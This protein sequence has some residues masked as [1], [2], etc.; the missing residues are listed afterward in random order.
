MWGLPQRPAA[1]AGQH[2]PCGSSGLDSGPS[3][4]LPL[5]GSEW[6]PRATRTLSL[7]LFG[8]LLE[9]PMDLLS[10]LKICTSSNYPT[11]GYLSEENENTNL[12]K[13][14][15]AYVHSSI[16]YNRK[17]WWWGSNTLAS[18][19]K[20]PMHWKRP[21]WWKRLMAGG[22]RADRGW[23]GWMASLTQWTWVWA[24]SKRSWRTEK[25]GM[26]QSMGSQRVGHNS[27]TEKQEDIE[28]N[29]SAHW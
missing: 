16:I 14:M 22:E 29:L 15:Y 21:S 19:C 23:D 10:K 3:P 9:C 25:P 24:N 1:E 17:D 26:L 20:Q 28:A 8:P 5:A 12:K 4:T 11:S 18:W 2:T 6:P 7:R 13:Y 27:T